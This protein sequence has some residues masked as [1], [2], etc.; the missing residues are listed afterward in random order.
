[1]HS[2][3]PSQTPIA[4]L[5]ALDVLRRRM[6]PCNS[7]PGM[8]K[9]PR[10]AETTLCPAERGPA[11][12]AT[13]TA[14]L[15]NPGPSFVAV[16][17]TRPSAAKPPHTSVSPLSSRC[18]HKGPEVVR[19]L[20]LAA[21]TGAVPARLV[22]LAVAHVAHHHAATPTTPPPHLIGGLAGYPQQPRQGDYGP[23]SFEYSP[24]PALT[25]R[26]LLELSTSSAEC[27]PPPRV[28]NV[29]R[30]PCNAAAVGRP[31]CGAGNT[32]IEIQEEEDDDEEVPNPDAPGREEDWQV[33][34][35]AFP[36]SDPMT[37]EIGHR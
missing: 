15:G 30:S 12:F 25:P 31:R 22:H 11:L 29:L 35:Q 9:H 3:L 28:Q 1:M 2:H 16:D 23:P 27:T 18:L 4:A 21:Q 7:T 36:S 10:P 32:K 37:S 5:N 34:A 20:S 33:F 19:C 26:D 24:P 8:R 14:A 6:D 13:A 17:L